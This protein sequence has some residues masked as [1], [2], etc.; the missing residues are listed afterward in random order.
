[1]KK[2]TTYC[3]LLIAASMTWGC[4][5]R[6][7]VKPET[8]ITVP[9]VITP[10]KQPIISIADLGLRALLASPPVKDPNLVKQLKTLSDFHQEFLTL[11]FQSQLFYSVQ[12]TMEKIDTTKSAGCCPCVGKSCPCACPPTALFSSS[13]S[14]AADVAL[15]TLGKVTMV[16]PLSST[17]QDGFDIFKFENTK[18]ASGSFPFQDGDYLLVI[19]SK[20]LMK[21]VNIP[22][23]VVNHKLMP[24]F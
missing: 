12:W 6:K 20:S 24:N 3:I 18:S 8:L 15:V 13:P 21:A 14:M 7:N 11:S 2:S 9:E 17:N 1:M 19:K 5:A 10:P 4:N 22:V 23:S 16:T